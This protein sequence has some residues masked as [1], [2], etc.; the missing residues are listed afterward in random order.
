MSMLVRG[1]PVAL[2]LAL[3]LS[4]QAALAAVKVGE[5]APDFTGTDTT[6][7]AVRLSDQRGKIVVLEWTNHDCPYVQKHYGAGNMQAQQEAATAEGAVWLSIISSA[8]GKQGHVNPQEA[9][10]LTVERD[11]APTT[12]ILDPKGEIGRRYGARTTPHMYVIDEAG[13]LRY[14]GGIDDIAS[15]DPDDVPKARQHVLIALEEL[16]AG[17]PVSEPVTRPYGCSVKY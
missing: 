15:S 2:L 13:I 16:R 9:D 3:L 8:P 10:R 17:K 14:M 4:A 7:N 6:G 12:V 5:P 11:A 1:A